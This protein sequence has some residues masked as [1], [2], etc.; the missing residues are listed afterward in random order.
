MAVYFKLYCKEA[1]E[2]VGTEKR[3]HLYSS[4]INKYFS[5]SIQVRIMAVF[6]RI[7]IKVI[8]YIPGRQL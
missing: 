3:G 1:S 2:L 5:T 7:H 8:Q 4:R 6:M